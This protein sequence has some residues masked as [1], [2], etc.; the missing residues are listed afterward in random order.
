MSRDGEVTFEM[1]LSYNYS[2]FGMRKEEILFTSVIGRYHYKM[3]LK[4]ELRYNNSIT[5]TPCFCR[6]QGMVLVTQE[7]EVPRT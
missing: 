4:K 2:Y 1:E 3:R 5:P 7:P 6:S